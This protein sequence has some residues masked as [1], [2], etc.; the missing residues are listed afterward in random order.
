MKYLLALSVLFF[1]TNCKPRTQANSSLEDSTSVAIPDSTIA[2]NSIGADTSGIQETYWKLTELRGR[3]IDSTPQDQRE[4]HIKFRSTGKVEGFG[5]C[6]G[7]GG[8]YELM[9]GD[10][11]AITN[12]IHTQIAC[13]QLDIENELYKA[14]EEADNYNLS[15]T[16]LALNK[17][18][19]APLARFRAVHL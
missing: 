17:A 19:M 4:I 15:D 13:P 5:G 9:P 6:N 14:L 18:R 16:A 3:I 2:N 8:N 11:I 7:F 1:L 12:I 10:K